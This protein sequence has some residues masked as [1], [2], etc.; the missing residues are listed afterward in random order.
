MTSLSEEFK[1]VPRC[2]KIHAGARGAMR[3]ILKAEVVEAGLSAFFSLSRV[4]LQIVV[5]P[6]LLLIWVQPI[7]E[8][9]SHISL[10]DASKNFAAANKVLQSGG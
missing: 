10:V 1:C 3:R 4:G 5:V 6:R 7:L 2:L 9:D 8:L